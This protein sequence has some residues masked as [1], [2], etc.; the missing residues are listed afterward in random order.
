MKNNLI[1]N[2]VLLAIGTQI[3]QKTSMNVALAIKCNNTN[4]DRHCKGM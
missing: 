2:L 1:I 3:V 4:D